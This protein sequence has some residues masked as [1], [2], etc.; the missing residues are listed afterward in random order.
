M[1]NTRPYLN[2]IIALVFIWIG[3]VGA[4]SFM[5]A[6][7]KFQAPNITTELGLGIGQL[8]FNALN[9][10]EITIALL[11]VG[12]LLVRWMKGLKSSCFYLMTPLII[13]LLQTFWLLPRLDERADLII[14]HIEVSKSYLHFYYVLL[15]ILKVLF[16]VLFGKRMLNTKN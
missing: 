6:W 2:T 11:L 12:L 9:R 13:L 15:E 16:L 8:V 7:L 14:Q 1:K 3:F 10:V 5:E 4:I